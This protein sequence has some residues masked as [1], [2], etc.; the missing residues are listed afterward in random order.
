MPKIDFSALKTA[1]LRSADP[2]NESAL[3]SIG[4]VVDSSVDASTTPVATAPFSEVP[5]VSAAPAPVVQPQAVAAP[6]PVTEAPKLSTMRANSQTH[7][8]ISLTSLKAGGPSAA[9]APVVQAPAVQPQAVAALEIT[10]PPA[11]V[12]L[13]PSFSFKTEQ[14][15]VSVE[16]EPV[17]VRAQLPIETVETQIET[18]VESVSENKTVVK[19][20]EVAQRLVEGVDIIQAAE[21]IGTEA[22]AKANELLAQTLSPEQ[23]QAAMEIAAKKVV[24]PTAQREFFTNLKMDDDFFDDP[25]FEGIVPA[26]PEKTEEKPVVAEA[27]VE[28]EAVIEEAVAELPEKSVVAEAPVETEAVSEEI[29]SVETVAGAETS[30]EAVSAEA[31]TETK[32]DYVEEVAKDLSAKR[33][34][35]LSKLFGERK[36]LVRAVAGFFALSLVVGGAFSLAPSMKTSAPESRLP[37]ETAMPN[38]GMPGPGPAGGLMPIPPSPAVIPAELPVF[39][40]NSVRRPNRPTK[41]QSKPSE[42]LPAVSAQTPSEPVSNSGTSVSP[43]TQNP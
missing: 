20:E 37:M 12:S 19:E 23:K 32:T 21:V 26:K 34:G 25:I 40:V 43:P 2:V 17:S 27:P 22:E 4:Q 38:G 16:P 18:V 3:P 14:P 30:P 7:K 33:Q 35:R 28:T 8:R 39:K 10:A 11:P 24:I 6:V 41:S 29:P 1:D 13:S 42:I 36:V 9:P 15:A 31:V 5:V